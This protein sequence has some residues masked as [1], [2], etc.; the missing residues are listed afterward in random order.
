ML[1][2]ESFLGLRVLADVYGLFVLG[3]LELAETV[4]VGLPLEELIANLLEPIVGSI[5]QSRPLSHV[6]SVDVGS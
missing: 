2:L 4:F 1:T 6:D 5:V 3:V